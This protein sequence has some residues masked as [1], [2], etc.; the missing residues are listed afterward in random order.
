MAAPR[1][2]RVRALAWPGRLQS[3][4][5]GDARAVPYPGAAEV[6]AGDGPLPLGG[7]TP[8]RLLAAL[9]VTPD[10]VVSTS[11]LIEA[12]W[13][14]A[15]RRVSGCA[16][17]WC[18]RAARTRS[19]ERRPA[20]GCGYRLV[21][22]PDEFAR[23]EATRLELLRIAAAEDRVEALLRLGRG[24][25]TIGDLEELHGRSPRS[26]S[27]GSSGHANFGTSRRTT[28]IGGLRAGALRP[29]RRPVPDRPAAARPALSG[30]RRAALPPTRHGTPSRPS[31]HDGDS[32]TSGG[33]PPST[34]VATTGLPPR[35]SGLPERYATRTEGG[36]IT[37]DRDSRHS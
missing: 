10:G 26:T 24:A 9:L 3:G 11:R 1:G 21:L 6:R 5:T 37:D 8:R 7:S 30:A 2:R 17:R 14:S 15:A 32:C 18:G 23:P 34:D 16:P 4:C 29:A 35:T 22:A 20:T 33:S 27:S 36:R 13:G 19:R 31:P 12:R 25:E 28:W